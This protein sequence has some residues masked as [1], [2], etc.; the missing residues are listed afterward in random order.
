MHVFT[1]VSELQVHLKQARNQGQQIGLVP[2][3]GALHQG[4]LSLISQALADNDLVVC[5]IFVNPTQFNNREDLAKYPRTEEQDL[6]LLRKAGCHIAFVPEVAEIYPVPSQLRLDFGPLETVME[7]KSRPGHFNGVGIVVS[8]LFHITLPDRAYFGQKDLQQVAII[9]QLVEDL[10]FPIDLVVVPTLRE[11]TGLALSSRNQRLSTIE[12]Q[13]APL[14]FEQLSLARQH[15]EEG[16]PIAGV[17]EALVAYFAST[18]DFR[19]DYFEVVDPKTLQPLERY[20]KS[21]EAALCIAIYLGSVRLID[22][23]LI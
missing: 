11:P 8:K 12:R 17:S 1:T 6:D 20:N 16:M 19:L 7:G 3:M 21:Q 2:T 4:H 22:N 5:S 14:V 15:L 10:S 13:R 18:A 23:L 9:K